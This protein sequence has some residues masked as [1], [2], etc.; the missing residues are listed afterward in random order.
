M[1]P[2]LAGV[3]VID[4][5]PPDGEANWEALVA[6]HGQVPPSTYTVR[7][8]RGGKH[9]YFLG[10]LPPTVGSSR[11]GLAPHV[12]T[13][14]AGSYVL[15]PPSRVGDGVYEEMGGDIEPVPAWVAAK[16]AE[17]RSRALEAAQTEATPDD[18][19]DVLRMRSW[20][21]QQP[22]LVEGENSDA[23][24]YTIACRLREGGLSPDTALDLLTEFQPAFDEEWLRDKIGNAYRYAENGANLYASAPAEQTFTLPK[25]VTEPTTAEARPGPK[26]FAD[27]LAQPDEPVRE[28]ISGWI[29]R[30]ITTLLSGPAGS[31]KSTLAL[32]WGL[33]VASGSTVWGRPTEQCG[34]LSLSYEDVEQHVRARARRIVDGLKLNREA[35]AEH[36]H[37]WDM[38]ARIG[39][40]LLKVTD[41]NV[42][43]QPFWE[44][45]GE[46]LSKRKTHTF[47]V[48][49]SSYNILRFSDGVRLNEDMV[50]AVFQILDR[51]CTV[52]NCTLLPLYHPTRAGVQ[53]GDSGNSTAWDSA[54]RARLGLKP[55]EGSQDTVTL[56][57]DK[58]SYAKRGQPVT[59]HWQNGVMIPLAEQETTLLE[60]AVAKVAIW[61]AEHDVAIQKTG[62]I[63]TFIIDEVERAAGWRPSAREIRTALGAAL[64]GGKLVYRRSGQGGVAGYYPPPSKTS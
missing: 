37:L 7:T 34:F 21:A 63:Q 28:L 39:E 12:D 49:D 23:R 45:L 54:P 14:G 61:A 25:L 2:E 26:S 9:L 53:R 1:V 33:C 16:I 38:K 43:V 31:Y 42:L 51:L 58:R 5:D 35:L 40:P 6:E 10:S 20:L 29:E 32:Q 13:R 62:T 44:E 46:W 47:I 19:G 3:C 11:K 15:M 50:N 55:V 17:G 64:V 24:A 48:A 30:G 36:A 60:D 4:L 8:P 41:D 56:S 22:P 27:V 59:L 57:V 18:P 52:A